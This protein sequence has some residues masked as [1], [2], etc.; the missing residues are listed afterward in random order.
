MYFV[1]LIDRCGKR[2]EQRLDYTGQAGIKK[3]FKIIFG[4]PVIS[5]NNNPVIIKGNCIFFFQ[6]FFPSIDGKYFLSQQMYKVK[7]LFIFGAVHF[8]FFQDFQ[9]IQ[10]NLFP[11]KGKRVV[12]IS[13]E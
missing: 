1:G 3:G 8:T 4:W 13:I 7:K 11:K 5:H 10:V 6:V 12:H 2:K 9:Y